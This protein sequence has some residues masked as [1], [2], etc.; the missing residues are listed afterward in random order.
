VIGSFVGVAQANQ[1]YTATVPFFS[2]CLD[3]G[4]GNQPPTVL[5]VVYGEADVI[6]Q[7]IKPAVANL[8]DF[9]LYPEGE[10]RFTPDVEAAGIPVI[11]PEGMTDVVVTDHDVVNFEDLSGLACAP[12]EE[13]SLVVM[14]PGDLLLF[15]MRLTDIQTIQP[16][17]SASGIVLA[18]EGESVGAEESAAPEPSSLLLVGIGLLGMLGL[19][20]RRRGMRK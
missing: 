16:T 1:L 5:I 6:E 15:A 12:I 2:D 14:H 11:V 18:F 19:G 4:A 8:N 7:R 13:H 17:V 3:T 20:L 9:R 10:L